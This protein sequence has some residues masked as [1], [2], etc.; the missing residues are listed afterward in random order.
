MDFM[1]KP[2][3]KLSVNFD[4]LNYRFDLVTLSLLTWTWS[5]V[6]DTEILISFPSAV[7]SPHLAFTLVCYSVG[8]AYLT[9]EKVIGT[10]FLDVVTEV[11]LFERCTY[12]CDEQ[13]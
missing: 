8:G 5:I 13:M 12:I 1:L 9:G 10:L 3:E 7:A 11:L 2:G 6:V 4:T